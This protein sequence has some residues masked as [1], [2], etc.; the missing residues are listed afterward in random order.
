MVFPG[1][2]GSGGAISGLG[3]HVLLYFESFVARGAS[4][5]FLSSLWQI[6]FWV[7]IHPLS[8][9]NCLLCLCTWAVF[10]V[11]YQ[12]RLSREGVRLL[13]VFLLSAEGISH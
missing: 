8:M 2:L 12:L 5:L 13:L 3:F 11:D 10:R 9:D 4:S 1:L 7:S 6:L